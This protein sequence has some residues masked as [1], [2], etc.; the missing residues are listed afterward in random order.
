MIKEIPNFKSHWAMSPSTALEAGA[1]GISAM[2][3]ESWTLFSL[4]SGSGGEGWGEEALESELKFPLSPN[5]PA[6]K[7]VQGAR[8]SSGAATSACSKAMDFTDMPLL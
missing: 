6:V 2:R 1:I 8:L 4:S 5:P 7:Y 3:C